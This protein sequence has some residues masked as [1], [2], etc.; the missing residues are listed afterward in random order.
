MTGN[1]ATEQLKRFNSEYCQR[2]AADH[3]HL[4]DRGQCRRQ[5]YSRIKPMLAITWSQV[6]AL[7]L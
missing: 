3:D 4:Y 2:S 6:Y 5:I 1:P 7:S